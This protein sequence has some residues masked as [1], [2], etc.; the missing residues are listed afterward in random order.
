MLMHHAQSHG[1]PLE[2]L[3]A[4]SDSDDEADDRVVGFKAAQ[5]RLKSIQQLYGTPGKS[6]GGQ[7]ASPRS[8]YF[9]LS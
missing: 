9:F 3:T 4:P 1:L 8:A 2:D 5:Q 7:N 6:P